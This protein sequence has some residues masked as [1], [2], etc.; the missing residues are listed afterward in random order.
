MP[1]ASATVTARHT[2]IVCYDIANDKPKLVLK[3]YRQPFY[4]ELTRNG[5]R[6][7]GRTANSMP[8]TIDIFG[9]RKGSG[10]YSRVATV[11]ANANGLFAGAVNKRGFTLR[12]AAYA[13]PRGDNASLAFGLWKTKDRYQPPFGR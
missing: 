1:A 13:K 3:A 11:K 6:F 8:E 5:F 2:Y 4:A 12:G 9:R 7:W 10:R